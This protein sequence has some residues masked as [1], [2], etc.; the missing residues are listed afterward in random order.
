M[1][2]RAPADKRFR[3]SHV[4]P[5]RRRRDAKPRWLRVFRTVAVLSLAVYAAYRAT[6]LVLTA[7]ALSITKVEVRGNTQLS[8]GEVLALVDGLRGQNILTARLHEW[9]NRLITSPW[10]KDAALRKVVPSTVEIIVSERMPVGLARAGARLYLVD[11][12]GAVIDE[13]GPQYAEFDLPII[14][15]LIEL[16]EG[17]PPT[18]DDAR[19]MLARRVLDDLGARP[20]LARRVSQVDVTDPYNVVA[21]LDGDGALLHLGNERFADRL[22][23]YLEMAAALRERVPEIDYVDLRFGERV[24]VRPAG[25]EASVPVTP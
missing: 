11:E 22:H 12:R 9:R 17:G 3:R 7:S 4:R 16:V 5:A 23:A 6:H 18:I 14:D 13:Y 21:L 10:V 24:Y 20:D 19:A 1:G 15:G 2:V 8:T 25:S